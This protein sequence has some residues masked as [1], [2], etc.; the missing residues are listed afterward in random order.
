MP[1]S[2]GIRTEPLRAL[3]M[4]LSRDLLYQQFEALH[5]RK[6]SA[7]QI[8][9]ITVH[10]DQGRECL[11]F[12]VRPGGSLTGGDPDD[13]RQEDAIELAQAAK[14]APADQA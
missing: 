5:H 13:R 11:E 7:K 2:D 12:R 9:A 10:L 3:A 1:H 4:H 14:G 6:P 8:D